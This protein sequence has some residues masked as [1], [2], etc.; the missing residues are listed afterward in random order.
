MTDCKD[1]HAFDM[2]GIESDCRIL[3]ACGDWD[4]DVWLKEGGGVRLVTNPD[5]VMPA[6]AVTLHFK[7]EFIGGDR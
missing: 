4:M 7:G 2:R 5:S 6:D 1:G 3:C